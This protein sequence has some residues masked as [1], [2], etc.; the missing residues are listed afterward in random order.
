[1]SARWCGEGARRRASNIGPELPTGILGS[2]PI[3]AA[4]KKAAGILRAGS[5]SSLAM[6]DKP[7]GECSRTIFESYLM[8]QQCPSRRKTF[9][10]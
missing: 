9:G 2:I 4:N 5:T 8:T 7:L 10:Y 3:S 6:Y 1:V